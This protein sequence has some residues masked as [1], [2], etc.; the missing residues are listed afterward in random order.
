MKLKSCPLFNF[1]ETRFL[2]NQ[3]RYFLRAVFNKPSDES[4]ALDKLMNIFQEYLFGLMNMQ[5][6]PQRLFQEPPPVCF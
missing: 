5:L 1:I 6:D 2:T 3:H 4:Y